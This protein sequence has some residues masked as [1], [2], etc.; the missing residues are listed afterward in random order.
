MVIKLGR[1]RVSASMISS[2]RS[3]MFFRPGEIFFLI[4]ELTRSSRHS[5]CSN[6]L[7]EMCVKRWRKKE[8][9]KIHD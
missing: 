9:A 8:T 2:L 5:S 7:A 6:E 1:L 3:P 4:V